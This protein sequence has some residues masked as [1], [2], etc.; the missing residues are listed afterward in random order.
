VRRSA[1]APERR[2]TIEAAAVDMTRHSPNDAAPRR[3]V[4]VCC[5]RMC[6][7]YACILPVAFRNDHPPFGKSKIGGA[8][9]AD[10][11]S[12]SPFN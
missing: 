1:R 9:L 2:N 11:V 7:I 5:S 3:R 4:S 8:S 12:P 10:T 6:E